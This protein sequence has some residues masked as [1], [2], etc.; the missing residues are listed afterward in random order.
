MSIIHSHFPSPPLYFSM[1]SAFLLP[2]PPEQ[3]CSSQ[4][5]RAAVLLMHDHLSLLINGSEEHHNRDLRS[6]EI[7]T[8]LLMMLYWLT[9]KKKLASPCCQLHISMK[10]LFIRVF[11]YV[12]IGISPFLLVLH[13]TRSHSK[14][15]GV[16]NVEIY[17]GPFPWWHLKTSH[18][19][20]LTCPVLFHTC[21]TSTFGLLWCF[22]W[23]QRYVSG[24]S[25]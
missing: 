17:L 24:P 22:L 4:W 21:E 25:L 14:T 9:P 8:I 15:L 20:V 19:E 11:T 23:T 16:C 18:F 10:T 7:C 6:V 5:A 2:C 3:A 13:F 12:F 1:F